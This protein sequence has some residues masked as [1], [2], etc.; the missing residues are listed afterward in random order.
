MSAELTAVRRKKD[1][2]IS[3]SSGNPEAVMLP[4]C[5]Y[6][7]GFANTFR[8]Y[9]VITVAALIRTWLLPT[10]FQGLLD[11]RITNAT[12]KHTFK[13]MFREFNSCP[14]SGR[15]KPVIQLALSLN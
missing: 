9:R 14:K 15:V 8:D 5:N 6:S 7:I 4:N 2:V 10:I 12:F 11:L 1:V 3:Q 13:R